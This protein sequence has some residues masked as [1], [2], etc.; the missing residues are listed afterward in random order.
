MEKKRKLLTI[1]EKL[2]IAV[3][4]EQGSKT[5]EQLSREH[6]IAHSTVYKYYYQK[7]NLL[8]AGSR[9]DFKKRKTLKEPQQFDVERLVYDWVVNER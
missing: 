6:G 3:S 9:P 5:A 2:K 4:Y 1:S 7:A 8:E